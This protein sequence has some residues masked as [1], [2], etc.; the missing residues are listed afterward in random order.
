[1]YIYTYIYIYIYLYLLV[2][3]EWEDGL[4]QPVCLS[5][6]VAEEM[7]I[8]TDYIYT[9][10]IYVYIYIH[11]LYIYTYIHIYVRRRR[12]GRWPPAGRGPVK[13]GS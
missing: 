10:Y 12:V 2:G 6:K 3:G 5:K 9:T 8:Y 1:M 7:Y 4:Q 13:G 11:I